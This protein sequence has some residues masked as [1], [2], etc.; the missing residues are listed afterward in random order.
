[1]ATPMIKLDNLTPVEVKDFGTEKPYLTLLL[2]KYEIVIAISEQYGSPAI[3]VAE[4]DYLDRDDYVQT[5]KVAG[6]YLSAFTSLYH[7]WTDPNMADEYQGY[8]YRYT[9]GFISE[10]VYL[11]N[12]QLIIVPQ[13]FREQI[14]HKVAELMSQMTPKPGYIYLVRAITPHNHYKI[15]LSV[16][17]SSRIE[18]MGVKLPFPIERLHTFPTNNTTLAEKQLHN[19]YAHKRLRGE[20]FELSEQEIQ[21]IYAIAYL[22]IEE[23]S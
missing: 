15:G 4:F 11:L 16:D 20:W 10:Y 8:S 21:N 1:M 14:E 13:H 3:Q 7:T 22:C 18:S 5:L 12:Q 2:G 9:L 17:P 19:Q 6:K 23:A